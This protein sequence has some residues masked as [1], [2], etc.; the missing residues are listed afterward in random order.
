M[1]QYVIPFEEFIQSPKLPNQD[2]D[3]EHNIQTLGSNRESFKY[4]FKF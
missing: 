3:Q 4:N 1:H 2:E